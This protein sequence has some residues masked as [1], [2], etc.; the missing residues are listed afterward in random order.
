[1]H[2]K[3][4]LPISSNN[5]KLTIARDLHHLK[6]PMHVNVY[7][8]ADNTAWTI[9]LVYNE[10]TNLPEIRLREQAEDDK[11]R[12][13]IDYFY[14]YITQTLSKIH[15]KMQ[16]NQLLNDDKNS[17]IANEVDNIIKEFEPKMKKNAII[18]AMNPDVLKS[19]KNKI[20]QYIAR[21][22]EDFSLA[23]EQDKK[24]E[25]LIEQEY[26]ESRFKKLEQFLKKV[27]QKIVV[28]QKMDA[29][30]EIDFDANNWKKKVDDIVKYLQ[31]NLGLLKEMYSWELE[32]Y[33][34]KIK[35]KFALCLDEGKKQ[36]ILSNVK[37][38]LN[39]NQP[40]N[41]KKLNHKANV[42]ASQF[43]TLNAQLEKFIQEQDQVEKQ[44]Q[45]KSIY[46]EL[47]LKFADINDCKNLIVPN[48]DILNCQQVVKKL[49]KISQKKIFSTN[50]NVL[51]D[52]ADR[53]INVSINNIQ[54]LIEK[55]NLGLE[56]FG[57]KP[58]VKNVNINGQTAKNIFATALQMKL[59]KPLK[60]EQIVKVSEVQKNKKINCASFA[61]RLL[62]SCGIKIPKK[63][64][65]IGGIVMPQAFLPAKE[66]TKYADGY[67]NK[68]GV[69]PAIVGQFIE[70]IGKH[71]KR[72]EDFELKEPENFEKFLGNKRTG[73]LEKIR[74][75][76]ASNM[77]SYSSSLHNKIIKFYRSGQFSG[78]YAHQDKLKELYS[79]HI[80]NIKEK[81]KN[82][83]ERWRKY[84]SQMY[85]V[86]ISNNTPVCLKRIVMHKITPIDIITH[87]MTQYL[88]GKFIS[89]DR[90]NICTVRLYKFNEEN[91]EKSLRLL[92]D[93]L[94]K[95]LDDDVK[96]NK[97]KFLGL[98]KRSLKS[99]FRSHIERARNLIFKG[100][101]DDN[102]DLNVQDL[103][104]LEVDILRKK[105]KLSDMNCL[106]KSRLNSMIDNAF[107]KNT[108]KKH[109]G[110]IKKLFWK[111]DANNDLKN[112][113]KFLY[114]LLKIEYQQTQAKKLEASLNS[115]QT[116]V[117]GKQ[118][119]INI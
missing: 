107:D 92:A 64:W 28:T 117:S 4:K 1:M 55:H 39:I 8:K 52:A 63:H 118:I 97:S 58:I 36:E 88:S 115:K 87:E 9:D 53:I 72:G 103:I 59:D 78:S 69:I 18:F 71:A 32:F 15:E 38:W 57:Q 30:A 70:K 100:L 75:L 108:N 98:F 61:I 12:Y 24:V 62:K 86:V 85:K 105:I 40:V 111:L 84:L 68:R 90:K 35:R 16:K 79:E 95:S 94:Q 3:Q 74:N 46:N 114:K 6:V 43:K 49:Q 54:Q 101:G 48:E 14:S 23:Q 37:S 31:C 82:S 102:L 42:H 22:R 119:T 81:Y 91:A 89:Q 33:L 17:P 112:S 65:G 45:Q 116:D 60:Y 27:E 25:W 47:L 19:I 41:T 99:R 20:H 76:L 29:L 26:I 2:N 83:P 93:D 110:N 51:D 5:A 104:R 10:I 77:R 21:I 113:H 56:C 7:L 11:C 109:A 50:A 73:L 44:K 67:K 106:C 13:S 96:K 66:S 34:D 80:N